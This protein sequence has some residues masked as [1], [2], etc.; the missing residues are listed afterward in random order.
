MSAIAIISAIVSALPELEPLGKSIIDDITG[1]VITAA[2][3]MQK[4]ADGLV[5][6]AAQQEASSA[7]DAASDADTLAKVAAIE[8]GRAA[9]APAMAETAKVTPAELVQ[10]LK[11]AGAELVHPTP[12]PVKP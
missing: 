8:A 10:E 1:G 4:M 11:D 2:Q 12:E 5:A 7:K 9:D 3:G 6:L